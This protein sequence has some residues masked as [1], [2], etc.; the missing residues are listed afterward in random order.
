MRKDNKSDYLNTLKAK[1]G[2]DWAEMEALP[3]SEERT[4]LLIDLMWFVQKHNN[5]GCDTFGGLQKRYLDMILR[6]RPTGCQ[7][8]H[9]VHIVGDR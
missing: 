5:M 6:T 3:V 2:E 1:M 4:C 7:V 8:V 9:I